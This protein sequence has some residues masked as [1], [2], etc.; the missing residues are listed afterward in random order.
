MAKKKKT[1]KSTKKRTT[2]K[3]V[4]KTSTRKVA[5]KTVKK[6]KVRTS[7]RK[8]AKK[9]TKKPAKKK[10]VKKSVKKASKKISRRKTSKELIVAVGDQCFWIYEGPIVKDLNELAQAFRGMQDYQF[11]HHTGESN[12]FANWVEEILAD[13]I[14]ANALKKAGTISESL[15][16]LDRALKKYS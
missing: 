13:K 2:K 1:T 15:F 12:D 9:T 4:K 16:V 7:V 5:K 6:T 11:D 14:C 3:V 10:A 8:S